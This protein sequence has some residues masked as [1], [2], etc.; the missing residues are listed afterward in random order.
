MRVAYSVA[1]RGRPATVA[2]MHAGKEAGERLPRESPEC[3]KKHTP[4]LAQYPKERD[5]KE[6]RIK[7]T[8]F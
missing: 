2:R 3:Q 8:V 7:V 4:V 5:R 1:D 6:G